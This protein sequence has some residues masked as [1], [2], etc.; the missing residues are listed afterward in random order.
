MGMRINGR[1]GSGAMRNGRAL[2]AR[3]PST[4]NTLRI[5]PTL[6]PTVTRVAGLPSGA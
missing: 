1:G 5:D 2:H 3:S 4:S 6:R